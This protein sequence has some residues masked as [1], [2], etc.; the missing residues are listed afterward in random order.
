M[1]ATAQPQN[2][3]KAGKHAEHEASSP[4]TDHL[5]SHHSAH[6]SGNIIISLAQK[7]AASKSGL[8]N[9]TRVR[10][11]FRKFLC[12]LRRQRRN[13]TNNN[14]NIINITININDTD[15]KTTNDTT[16]AAATTTTTFLRDLPFLRFAENTV[17]GTQRNPLLAL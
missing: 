15:T 2:P 14:N 7:V 5:L 4:Q 10:C 3:I 9:V 16:T 8:S 1:Q 11:N 12:F 17:H 6:L 13:E